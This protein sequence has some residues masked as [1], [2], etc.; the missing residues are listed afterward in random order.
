MDLEGRYL[1]C[2]DEMSLSDDQGLQAAICTTP[3]PAVLHVISG[4]LHVNISTNAIDSNDEGVAFT[5][6]SRSTSI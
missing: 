6:S 3:T 4:V 1:S 2:V 5:A